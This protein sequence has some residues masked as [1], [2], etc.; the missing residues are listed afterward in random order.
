MFNAQYFRTFITLVETGSFTHTARRLDMTQPGVSQHIRKLEQYLD[1]PLLNRQGRRFMLTETGRRA[2]DYA[3]KLFAEHEHFRHSLDDDSLHAGDC[4][5]A[6][7]G[8]VGLM[9]YPFILGY[10]QM[11]PGLTVSYSFAFNQ[12]IV[13]DVLAGRYDLGI[14]TEMPNQP[15]LEF[16]PWHQ[17]P[18]CLVVPADFAGTTLND[19]MALGFMNYSDGINHASQ[20]LRANFPTEF[21]SMNQFPKQGFTNEVAMV[22]DAVAR[23]LGFTVISRLVLETSPWQRQVKELALPHHVYETLF[24]VTRTRSEM[25]RRYTQLLED[26]RD[27][28]RNMLYGLSEEPDFDA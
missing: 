5:I 12:D 6:S 16:D 27:Q 9:F 13:K 19:L 23:G 28:R 1:K 11:H 20:L 18:L 7:P 4:R 14:V 10:Q 21:R 2:Y 15:D 25:P 26:F 8:S 22:L 24:I 3:V 17:E